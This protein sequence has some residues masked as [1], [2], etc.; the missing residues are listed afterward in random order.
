MSMMM[1][2]LASTRG[3]ATLCGHDVATQR[4][5]AYTDLGVCFQSDA[6][7]ELL[8]GEECLLFFARIKGIEEAVAQRL[9]K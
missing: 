9:G 4:G 6:M 5:A 3:S 7:F 8:T 2:D 1:G